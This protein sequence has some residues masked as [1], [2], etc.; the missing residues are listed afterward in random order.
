[1]IVGAVGQTMRTGGHGVG[2]DQLDGDNIAGGVMGPLAS[3]VGDDGDTVP[4]RASRSRERLRREPGPPKSAVADLD[5]R[6]VTGLITSATSLAQKTLKPPLLQSVYGV[7]IPTMPGEPARMQPSRMTQET[8]ETE[9][10]A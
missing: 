2:L 7:G 1:V 4:P 8:R 5:F 9:G 10:L 3:T 6:P